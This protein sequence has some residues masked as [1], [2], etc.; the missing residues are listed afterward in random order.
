MEVWRNFIWGSRSCLGVCVGVGGVILQFKSLSWFLIVF[1]V[2]FRLV[3]IEKK[4]SS[5]PL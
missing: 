3:S 4:S 1:R 2:K 5:V